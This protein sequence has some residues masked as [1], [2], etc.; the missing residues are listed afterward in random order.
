MGRHSHAFGSPSAHAVL[1]YRQGEKTW[2]MPLSPA[3]VRVLEPLLKGE[4]F[5]ETLERLDLSSDEDVPEVSANLGIWFREWVRPG[6]FGIC[7]SERE[8][9]RT[10]EHWAINSS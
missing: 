8:L 7:E 2:R 10:L 5:G 6:T 4:A 9:E 3:T 1:V